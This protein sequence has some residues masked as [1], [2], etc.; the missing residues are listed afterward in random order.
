[1]DKKKLCK[2]QWV[3]YTM[4]KNLG[5]KGGQDY[6]WWMEVWQI[7]KGHQRMLSVIEFSHFTSCTLCNKVDE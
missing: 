6:Q 3:R 2:G 4:A 7:N 1:M 5:G